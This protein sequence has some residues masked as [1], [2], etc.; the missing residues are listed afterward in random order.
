[1][2]IKTIIFDLGGV[3]INLNYA[4]TVQAFK[5]LG[6]HNFDKIYSQFKQSALFDRYE[7][8]QIDDP[9]F[10]KG[11]T[12]ELDL[13]MEDEQFDAA[14]NAMLLDLPKER[15]EFI[16]QLRQ[17]GFTTLLFSNTNGV[18][19]KKVFEICQ[20]TA[21]VKDFSGCFDKEY[22]S[23]TF[24][25]RKPHKESFEQIIKNH[26]LK[27]SE[28]LFVDDTIQHIEGA[29]QAGIHTMLIDKEHSIFD[30][31]SFIA[32]LNQQEKDQTFNKRT[33]SAHFAM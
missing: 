13:P 2:T 14:W 3:I 10:R 16:R 1:M 24:G 6:G 8:G 22:Y 19:L 23:H 28:I 9:A 27:A 5:S 26:N 31:P 21:E 15:L 32:Q 11:L 33:E 25:M 12:E 18:H 20:K 17:E 4:L 7:T 30:I 29:K